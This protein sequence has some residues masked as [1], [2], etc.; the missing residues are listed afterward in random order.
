M[1]EE[2]SKNMRK[3]SFGRSRFLDNEEEEKDEKM[4]EGEVEEVGKAEA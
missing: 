3:N 1:K 2:N 4:E